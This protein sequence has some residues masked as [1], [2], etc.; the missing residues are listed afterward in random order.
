MGLSYSAYCDSQGLK[1]EM[2]NFSEWDKFSP[3]HHTI[4]AG[5]RFKAGEYFSP[6][7]WSGKPYNSKQITIAPDIQILKVWDF[8]ILDGWVYVGDMGVGK[9]LFT[10]IANNDGLNM[11]D[12][13]SWFKYP[14]STGP[15]QIICWNKDIEY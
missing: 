2:F 6:R 15:M 11:E 5:H 3:K 10:T 8:K 7:V 9:Q 1:I 13:K 12:L 4:R 14:K